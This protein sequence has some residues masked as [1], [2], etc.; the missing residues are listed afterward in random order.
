MTDS[1]HTLFTGAYVKCITVN[2]L[3][4]AYTSFLTVYINILLALY[5]S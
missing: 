2:D 4:N 5:A 3:T 1:K